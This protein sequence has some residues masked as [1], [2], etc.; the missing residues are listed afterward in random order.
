MPTPRPYIYQD[1]TITAT[2]GSPDVVGVS[3][4]F[5]AVDY[6]DTLW[7]GGV[8]VPILE[9]I[10]DTHLTLAFNW[11][12]TTA[13]GTADYAITAGIS[14]TDPRRY[15]WLV[16]QA[17]TA[18]EQ[19]P[20]DATAARDAAV[21]AADDANTYKTAA[22]DAAALA[23]AWASTAFN[24][25]VPGASPGSRSALHYSTVASN[26]ASTAG[27]SA[28]AAATSAQLSN[29]WANKAQDTDVTTPGSRSAMHWSLTAAANVATATA[30]AVALAAAWASQPAGQDVA[31]AAAGS[32]SA[33]HYSTAAA[34]SASTATTQAALAADWSSKGIGLDVTT[35]GTRSALHWSNSASNYATAASSSAAAAAS[36]AAAAEASAVL[37][38]NPDFGFITDG[39]T[40]FQDFGT[41]T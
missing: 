38:A 15:G 31:G 20:A 25:D 32:R 17:F 23:S 14:A 29:D 11:P 8:G 34:T 12:G 37:L 30:A 39:A 36:S 10:D 5:T 22:Q 1:G 3:T 4:A 9:V 40:D 6:A 33:L 26:Y 24:T 21:A 13:L 19:I 18:L 41:I 2:N 7:I 35:P 27:T 16:A 28:G